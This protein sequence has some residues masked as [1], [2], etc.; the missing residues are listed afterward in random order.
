MKALA[1]I[2]VV[3][4]LLA[5]FACGSS[6]Q[7]PQPSEGAGPAPVVTPQAKATI[8]RTI[9]HL[10]KDGTHTQV[11]DQITPQEQAAERAAREQYLSGNGYRPDIT[12]D[13]SCAGSDMWMSNVQCNS[14]GYEICFYGEGTANLADY[15][16]CTFDCIYHYE[17]AGNV[18]SYWPGDEYGYF[19]YYDASLGIDEDFDFSASQNCTN[20]TS[21]EMQPLDLPLS[22]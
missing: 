9:V 15:S 18:A 7:P 2:S 14:S 6:D 5:T 19:T 13:S 1:A 10:N 20:V 8:G 4:V 21:A 3:P 16:Y 22:D 12:Q 11:D 17:W